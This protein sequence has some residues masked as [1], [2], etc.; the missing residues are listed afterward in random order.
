MISKGHKIVLSSCLLMAAEILGKDAYAQQQVLQQMETQQETTS[1]IDSNKPDSSASGRSTEPSNEQLKDDQFT[2][3]KLGMSLLK[4]IV[5]DQRA[6][7]TSPAH[8]RLNDANWLLPVAAIA[9]ASLESDTHISK[10]LTRSPARV[11]ESTTFSNYGVAAFGGAT[12]GLYLLGKITHNDHE[13]EAAFLSGE[14]AVDAVAVTHFTA[15]RLQTAATNGRQRQRNLL[16]RWNFVPVRSC[17]CGLGGRKR[18][19]S[20]ISGSVNKD[21]CLWTRFGCKRL[22]R[23]GERPF[24]NRRPC[25]QRNRMVHGP[26]RLSCPPRSRTRRQQLGNLFRRS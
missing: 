25:W 13:Q 18:H 7:W 3:T 16:A 2:E 20:R 11:R 12:G 1:E 5:L 6:V 9:A 23:N 14:A 15:I 4:N 17:Y 26:I 21:S 24:S 8:L 22:P 19:G 10:A